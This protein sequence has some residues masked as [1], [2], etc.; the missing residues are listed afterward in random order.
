[1]LCVPVTTKSY[2]DLI[3]TAPVPFSFFYTHPYQT[4][5]TNIRNSLSFHFLF[6]FFCHENQLN[7]ELG[8]AA[9]G[10]GVQGAWEEGNA[11]RPLECSA[12]VCSV[13]LIRFGVESDDL[14]LAG[15]GREEMQG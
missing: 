4:H 14:P 8:L 2:K 15:P 5:Q 9:S 7:P 13:A 6:F 11:A 10:V 3:F 12:F 1:M